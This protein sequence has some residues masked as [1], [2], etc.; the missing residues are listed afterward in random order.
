MARRGALA[1]ITAKTCTGRD[2]ARDIDWRKVRRVQHGLGRPPE[3]RGL[4]SDEEVAVADARRRALR[5]AHVFAFVTGA[6]VGL[7]YLRGLSDEP[8]LL[9]AAF[10]ASLCGLL[11]T[12]GS[13]SAGRAG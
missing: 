8:V 4:L 11:A 9:A 12:R 7:A 1:A 5:L 13:Y 10:C 2:A 3:T 6:L